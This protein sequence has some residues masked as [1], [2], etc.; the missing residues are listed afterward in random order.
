VLDEQP[1]GAFELSKESSSHRRAR[2]PRVEIN[3][4]GNIALG[5][6]M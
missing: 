4:V 2:F 5:T 1:R 3:R 6:R